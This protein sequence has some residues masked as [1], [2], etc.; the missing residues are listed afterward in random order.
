MTDYQEEKVC[1]NVIH[2]SSKVDGKDT[3]E[4]KLFSKTA[5]T[6]QAPS[7]RFEVTESIVI[8]KA[9]LMA[10]QYDSWFLKSLFLFTVFIC[11][12]AYGLDSIIRSIYMTYA[13]NAYDTHSLLSTVDVISMVI[14]AVGQIFFARLSDVFGR[15]SLFIVSIVLY[16]VGTVIQSQAYDVQRYAAGSVFYNVGLVGAM[17]QVTLI[18]S[19]CSTLKWRLFYNFVPAWPAIITVWISGNV[20]HVANP[21][22]NWSWGIAMWAF[23]FP[24]SCIPLIACV[25]HMRWKVRNSQ[26]WKELQEEKSF[27]QTHGLVQTLVQLFWRLDV[28]GVILL[29]VF[30]GCICVPLTVAGGV[31]TRWKSAKVIA[32]FV[33]GFVLVPFFIHWESKRAKFPL[34]PFQMLK[35]RGIWAPLWIYFLIA[36]IYMMAAEYLYTI[37]LVA[38]NESDLS[39]TRIS[40]L[41]SFVAA[42][43]SPLVGILVARSSRLKPYTVVGGMLY[44]VTLGLFYHYRG[45]D[46]TGKGVI[47]AMVV[48]GITSCLYDYPISVSIQTV[49][50]HEN[51]ANVSAL[52]S[53][54]FRIGGAVGAAVSGAIWTQTLYPKLLKELGDSDMA[55]AA[56]NS[57]LDFMAEHEWGTP[58]REAMVEAFQY[59]QKYEVLVGLIFV[60][61]MFVMTFFLRD[62]PLNE[63]F[64]QNLND[65][66]YVKENDDP[67]TDWIANRFSRFKKQD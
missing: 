15:L 13:M 40:S 18:L 46:D 26:E 58:V 34:A 66:E 14:S 44:F 8:R 35:D 60:A 65:D 43:L 42:I 29:S 52:S 67:I 4:E 41:Y 36:F 49:T 56:Y 45:G 21:L 33:L 10:K 59:V 48:W 5:E 11:S 61:P 28:V 53:T 24:L 39:A 23:I 62:P 38:G 31:S 57:P 6:E 50:S 16:V 22:E 1:G 54:L 25:L 32:P 47:G 27:Y 19:D 12:F 51:L 7:D 17:F 2:T 30:T 20:V 64:G 9:E 55:E 3:V 37:L 63:E